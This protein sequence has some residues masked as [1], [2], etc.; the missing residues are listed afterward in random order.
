MEYIQDAIFPPESMSLE[1][2]ETVDRLV[3]LVR[4]KGLAALPSPSKLKL[5]VLS[6]VLAIRGRDAHRLLGEPRP[7]SLWRQ[8]LSNSAPAKICE[9][10]PVEESLPE[11][12]FHP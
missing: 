2:R 8:R 3:E 4:A 7:I 11:V 9:K 5:S 10:E 1:D 6:R 12:P